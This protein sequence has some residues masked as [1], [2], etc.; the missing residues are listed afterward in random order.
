MTG[1]DTLIGQ[2]IS[3]YKVTRKLG[4]GGM[5]VVY[6]AEDSR[7]GRRV[8]VIGAGNTAIDCATIAKRLGAEYVTMIYRRSADECDACISGRACTSAT[9]NC[10]AQ[11]AS[12]VP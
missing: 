10:S 12:I 4:S 8:A 7:L 1:S 9:F 6:E 11:C 3:H 2:A 5:G